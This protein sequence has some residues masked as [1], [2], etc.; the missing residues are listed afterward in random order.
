MIPILYRCINAA[1][2]FHHTIYEDKGEVFEKLVFACQ[3][4][5]DTTNE[6]MER[7]LNNLFSTR[8]S[9]LAARGI[10]FFALD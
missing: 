7:Y 9:F 3:E 4:D 5:D 1:D 10:F 8:D 2:K 6:I